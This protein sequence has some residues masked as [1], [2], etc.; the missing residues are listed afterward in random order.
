MIGPHQGNLFKGID[1][2]LVLSEN[3]F[4]Q[5]PI[6]GPDEGNSFRGIDKKTVETQK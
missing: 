6:I 5:A 1:K 2:N 3:N 4:W